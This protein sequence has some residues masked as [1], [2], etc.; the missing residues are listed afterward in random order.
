[1]CG[2]AASGKNAAASV[3][4]R[5]WATTRQRRRAGMPPDKRGISP[6]SPARGRGY[7]VGVYPAEAAGPRASRRFPARSCTQGIRG[8]AACRCCRRRGEWLGLGSAEA[9][10]G[11]VKEEEPSTVCASVSGLS[12]GTRGPARGVRGRRESRRRRPKNAFGSDEVDGLGA[13]A[14]PRDA[15]AVLSMRNPVSM[16]TRMALKTPMAHGS[17]ATT[18]DETAEAAG[19][20]NPSSAQP[21]TINVTLD[22]G[23]RESDGCLGA[24]TGA[25]G[26]GN[27]MCSIA[28]RTHSRSPDKAAAGAA[29][30]G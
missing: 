30:R 4:P 10:D 28:W 29:G 16:L 7:A 17:R 19:G 21:A 8:A 12:G 13:E 25:G 27:T 20:K 9:D 5:V 22:I 14:G 3:T 6:S 24:G 11:T 26:G 1:V 2:A 23:E 15:G 18:A